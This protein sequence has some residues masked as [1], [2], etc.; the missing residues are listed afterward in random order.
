MKVRAISRMKEHT[1]MISM[2]GAGSL[3]ILGGTIL[4][5]TE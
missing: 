5:H 3:L 4:M 1:H 2:H